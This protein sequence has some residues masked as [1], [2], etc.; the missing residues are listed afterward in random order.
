MKI[1]QPALHLIVYADGTTNQ[2]QPR[3]P[4]PPAK[5]HGLDTLFSLRAGHLAV[6]QGTLDYENRAA[7]FDFQDRYVR[8]DFAANDV[9]AQLA[10]IPA[11]STAPE[12]YRI[13]AG[14]RDMRVIRG[15]NAQPLAQPAKGYMQATIDLTRNAAILRSLRLTSRREGAAEQTLT[16]SGS[17]IDFNRPRWQATAQGVLDMRLLEPTTGYNNS[18][19]GL[20]RINLA[21]QEVTGSFASMEPYT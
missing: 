16:V 15:E 8:L 13:E 4:R 7:D 19:D 2:P 6:E 11:S 14:A 3:K 18:P 21:A 9:S 20:A 1:T 12:T 17:L 10:Y 5:N